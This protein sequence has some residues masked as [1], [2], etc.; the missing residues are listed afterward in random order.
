MSRLPP[1]PTLALA[2]ILCGAACA[3]GDTGLSNPWD[4]SNPGRPGYDYGGP[5]ST[6]SGVKSDQIITAP[7]FG[8]TG[9]EDAGK[10]D[11][12]STA[13]AI[14]SP[15]MVIK[16]VHPSAL[17][18]EPVT[19]RTIALSGIV[20]GIP[21]SVTWKTH[22]GQE[23]DAAGVPF[24]KTAPIPLAPGD[25]H[26]TVTATRGEEIQ[27]DSIILTV[28]T[29]FKFGSRVQA[30]PD[31][32]FVGQQDVKTIFTISTDL[33]KNFQPGSLQLIQTD[34]AGNPV[35]GGIR[36]GMA[37][38]GKT[39]QTGDEIQGDAIFTARAN[40]DGAEP[41]ALYFRVQAQV[42]TAGNPMLAHSEVLPIEVIQPITVEQCNQITTL[43][44][45]A[46]SAYNEKIASAGQQAAAVAALATLQDSPQVAEAGI[47]G[48]TGVWVRYKNGL[49]GALQ[50]S[51]AG[52]RGGAGGESPTAD[53]HPDLAQLSTGLL[54]SVP[55]G[56][57]RALLLSPNLAELGDIDE[58]R[59]IWKTFDE[60]PCPPYEVTEPIGDS[61]ANLRMFQDM[62]RYGVISVVSHGDT[63]FDTLSSQAKEAYGWFHKGAQEVIWT[64][65]AINCQAFKREVGGQCKRDQQCGAGARCIIQDLNPEGQPQGICV[66]YAQA[67][68]RRGRLVFGSDRYGILPTFIRFHARDPYPN[69]VVY[70]GA[71]RSAWNGSM[72]AMFFGMG[73][74]A[75]VGYS[76]Y[77]KSEFASARG[78][79]FFH[80]LVRP[81]S[82]T[83]KGMLSGQAHLKLPDPENQTYLRLIGAR[84]LDASQSELLN[85][86][87]ETGK[88][89]G[90]QKA[91]DGRVIS[92]LGTALPVH[93]K[94]MGILSTGL[95]FTTQTGELSQT[96]CIAPGRTTLTFWWR[97][98]SEEFLEWCGTQYQ[99]TFQVTIESDAGQLRPVSVTVDDMCPALSC[100]G[101]GSMYQQFP[102]FPEIEQSPVQFDQGDTYMMNDWVQ[103]RVDLAANGFSAGGPITLRL[104]A[105]DKGDSIFDSAILVDA[106]KIE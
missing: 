61:A 84:N 101:C 31:V 77:V 88:S 58:N 72:A 8:A 92:Q 24:W 13:Y 14:E 105:T 7:D 9:G 32:L 59:A 98:F 33:Y 82:N 73:A 80:R 12:T 53:D 16:I 42:V 57:R 90:W 60:V 17:R 43:Q 36:G 29:T 19:S 47:T 34:A 70:L 27:T 23:G 69:S 91:G 78:A 46:T 65:E 85:E 52:Y 71:C 89:S 67:D 93:G 37:D 103:T 86:S 102:S 79:E 48:D 30:R 20:T 64:G 2:L 1:L 99:D 75:I 28:N 94:F 26:I 56:S 11:T 100:I 4:T 55:V 87:W 62:H 104:F 15:E 6:D 54:S 83:G 38:D 22:S 18:Q 51:A 66:D 40:L 39:A 95:G 21:D 3:E 25:N 10:K 41:G 5:I 44:T 74:R 49:L 96:F 97:F 35:D 68:L 63:Y 106:V 76:D 81:D 50:L 45:S